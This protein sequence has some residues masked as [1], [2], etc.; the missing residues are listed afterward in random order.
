MTTP[1]WGD[2]V[3]A[4]FFVMLLSAALAGPS[5]PRLGF[6]AASVAGSLGMVMA[7]ACRTTG[8]HT[9]SWWLVELGATAV[10]TAA[11]VGG[12]LVRLRRQ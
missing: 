6:A 11:A 10:L 8:H 12:L 4:S 9:G 3:A 2:V 5:L 7:V 1:L